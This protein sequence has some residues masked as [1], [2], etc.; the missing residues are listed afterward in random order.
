MKLNKGD[1]V[2]YDDYIYIV[3]AVVWSTLYLQ[4]LSDI[5]DYDYTI[6]QLYENGFRD[7]EIIKNDKE[8]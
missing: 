5:G 1:C 4:K 6:E 3:V 8:N 7:I 2:K